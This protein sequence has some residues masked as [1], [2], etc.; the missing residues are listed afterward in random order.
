MLSMRFGRAG[1]MPHAT[2]DN[3]PAHLDDKNRQCNIH[4]VMM[5][6]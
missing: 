2:P 6:Q 4:K 1:Y 5:S 3:I